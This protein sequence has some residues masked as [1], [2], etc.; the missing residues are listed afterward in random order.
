MG[1]EMCIRDS[2]HSYGDVAIGG[3]A[4]QTFTL[5]NSGD[6]SASGITG[7]AFANPTEYTF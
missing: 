2:P 1:S 4:D 6:F 3:I 5:S 7:I